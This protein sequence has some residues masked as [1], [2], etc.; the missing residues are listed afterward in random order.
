[1]QDFKELAKKQIIVVAHRGV[2]G[3][4]IPCNTMPAYKAAL[5]QG[6]DMLEIDVTR[7]KDDNL[8]IFHPGMERYHLNFDGCIGN[9]TTGEVKAL[10]YC[11]Q[12]RT[13]TQF[14]LNTVDEIFEEFK[15]KCYINV[16]KFWDNPELIYKAVK[17]HGITEQVL[18]KSTVKDNV[19]DVL[20]NVAPE[21]PFLAIVSKEHPMHQ[22]L[23]DS[24]INYIGAEVLFTSE[25]DEVATPEF[26]DMMH[27]E[28][29]LVWVNSIIYSYKAQLAAEHSDDRSLCDSPDNGW[30]WL[31]KR[32][33][34][35]I[36][37]DWPGLMIDYL[38]RN[39]LYYK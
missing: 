31:A 21:L 19:I 15:G 24:G 5:M 4:N 14:G 28:G 7:S 2:A 26:I 37:T 1:M 10:R 8:F 29:Y 34:D 11:N 12:D 30:G 16:D 3:G 13:P 6:A 35:F 27:R 9:L 23:K 38:K 20:K 22:R 39:N 33:F 32:N 36:Q 18:V 17:R 25:S